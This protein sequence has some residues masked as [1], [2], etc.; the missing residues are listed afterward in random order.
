MTNTG[1]KKP[2]TLQ[3]TVVKDGNDKTV[4]VSVPRFV[5]H[6]K[7]QKYFKKD[8]RYQAHDEENTYKVGDK[9]EM[10]ETKP[11]SKTKRFRVTKKI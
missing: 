7:Y 6:E 3:G 11:I 8:K 4:V 5:K 1:T 10:T 2:K 9:V